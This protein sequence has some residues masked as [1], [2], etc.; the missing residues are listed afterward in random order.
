M[1]HLDVWLAHKAKGKNVIDPTQNEI[2]AMEHASDKAGEYIESLGG[3][4]DMATFTYEEWMTL[5]EVV[6]TGFTEKLGELNDFPLL[7]A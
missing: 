7:I 5:I 3:K 6:C 4:T 2:A 1:R